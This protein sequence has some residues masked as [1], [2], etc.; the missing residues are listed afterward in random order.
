MNANFSYT[1]SHILNNGSPE[2][3]GGFRP[4][5]CVRDGCLMD[6]GNGTPVPVNSF[7]Q[8]DYGNADLDVRQRFTVMLNYTLPLGRSLHGAT[9]YLAKGWS[10]NAIYAY[11]TGLPT[12]ISEQGGGPPGTITNAGG[13]LGFRGGDTPNQVGDPNAGR[14]H[15]LQAWFNTFAFAV[16]APGLLGNA[17]ATAFTVH[18][19]GI[20]CVARQGPP[21]PGDHSLE[22][23]AESFN[24]TNTPN[25]AEPI[26]SR[27]SDVR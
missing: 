27:I 14:V 22:F 21:R 9:A 16:Q 8:Y 26:P 1:W 13:I 4:V 5:E 12:S 24:V 18:R 7:L 11:S 15:T 25:F 2:G 20:G 19:S 6:S 3:E 17:S 10:V 23:R